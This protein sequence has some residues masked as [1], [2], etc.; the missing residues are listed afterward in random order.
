MTDCSGND[1]RDANDWCEDIQ[2]QKV[3]NALR[4]DF[5]L[6]LQRVVD[7]AALKEIARL[8]DQIREITRFCEGWGSCQNT[9]GF[10]EEIKNQW[11][12]CKKNAKFIK[13]L[14]DKGQ[15]PF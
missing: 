3:R 6:V 15:I 14:Q 12:L 8:S 5:P 13:E 7:K 2:S 10:L 9:P 11:E 4:V 1:V